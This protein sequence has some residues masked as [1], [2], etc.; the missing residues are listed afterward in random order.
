[1]KL[2]LSL[3]LAT[4]QAYQSYLEGEN[5]QTEDLADITTESGSEIQ[6]EN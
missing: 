1:M 2:R 4:I 3:Q 5:L 6:P